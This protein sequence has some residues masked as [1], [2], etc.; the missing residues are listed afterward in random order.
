M[1]LREKRTQKDPLRPGKKQSRAFSTSLEERC[2]VFLDRKRM[3]PLKQGTKG[4]RHIILLHRHTRKANNY[5]TLEVLFSPSHKGE[6]NLKM[7]K[8][9]GG[10]TS[11]SCLKPRESAE[12]RPASPGTQISTTWWKELSTFNSRLHG[13]GEMCLVGFCLVL[14]F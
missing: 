10:E 1:L 8:L 6:G 9:C 7:T 11:T 3:R 14:F 5:P 2:F 4:K 13:R 12:E